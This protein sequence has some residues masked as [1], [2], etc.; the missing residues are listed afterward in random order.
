MR[1]ISGRVNTLQTDGDIADL[2]TAIEEY[3]LET[4][5][6][7]MRKTLLKQFNQSRS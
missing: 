3:R 7:L 1:Q 2:R 6:R 4:A 5:A